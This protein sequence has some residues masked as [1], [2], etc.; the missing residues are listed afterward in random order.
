M[1]EQCESVRID[2]EKQLLFLEFDGEVHNGTYGNATNSPTV[3][4]D[5]WELRELHKEVKLMKKQ[6]SRY[7]L[8][9]GV[10]CDK[11]LEIER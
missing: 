3:I 9:S 11:I 4:I 7:E 2:K 6:I 8:I 5:L 10:D 1:N